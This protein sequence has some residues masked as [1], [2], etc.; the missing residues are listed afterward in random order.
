MCATGHA[1]PR[2]VEAIAAR[3]VPCLHGGLAAW[4][5]RKLNLA[6]ALQSHRRLVI[7]GDPGCGKTTLL[8]YLA[9]TYARA[10]RDGQ[11][12]VGER[13]GLA[14]AGFLPVLLPLRDLGRH[15]LESSPS[16][17]TDGPALLL[18][19]LRTYYQNQDICLP[20]DFF[21]HPLESGQAVV[22]LDGMDELAESGLR[23]RVARLIEK[24]AL[25]YPDCRYVVTSREVGYSGAA[26]VGE[27]FGLAQVR[28]RMASLRSTVRE[29]NVYRWAGRMLADAGRWRLRARIEARVRRYH[30]S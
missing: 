28:E 15:L 16:A 24:F 23:Q 2:I 22:L 8:A 18:A 11:D 20:L 5:K 7:I 1:H 9:L 14:E 6:R 29:F 30:S 21:R 25:R 17:G 12:W 27:H 3:G 26:R 4:E 13:L 10:L 19:F